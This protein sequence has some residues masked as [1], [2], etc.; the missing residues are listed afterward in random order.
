MATLGYK[1][2]VVPLEMSKLEMTSRFMAN[3]SGIDVTKILQRRLAQGEK[4]LVEEKYKKWVN[5]TVKKKTSVVGQTQTHIQT[6]LLFH[7]EK[8]IKKR[9]QFHAG[10]SRNLYTDLDLVV[11][12]Q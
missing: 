10:L 6:S 7:L 11:L 3:R 1:V 8:L 5:A 9:F 12:N 2:V 4:E